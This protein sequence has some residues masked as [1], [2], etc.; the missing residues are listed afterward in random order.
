[1]Y[2]FASHANAPSKDAELAVNSGRQERDFIGS[3]HVAQA[4]TRR[5]MEA[6]YRAEIGCVEPV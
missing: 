3:E 2:Y 1:M 5:C 4:A 6:T